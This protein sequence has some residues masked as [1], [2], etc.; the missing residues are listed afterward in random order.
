MNVISNKP[1]KRIAQR[2][3]TDNFKN[4]NVTPKTS[5]HT[6]TFVGSKHR[7]ITINAAANALE[8]FLLLRID[9]IISSIPSF[10][11]LFYYFYIKPSQRRL[12]KRKSIYKAQHRA[13]IRK[14]EKRNTY[15]KF[16]IPSI[17]LCTYKMTKKISNKKHI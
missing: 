9:V 1:A 6:P 13:R 5:A 10:S 12:K 2:F 3:A 17:I 8:I 11:V 15:S 4:L 14:S 7:H 16:K